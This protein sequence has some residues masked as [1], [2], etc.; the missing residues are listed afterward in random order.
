MKSGTIAEAT[1]TAARP[2]IAAQPRAGSDGRLVG[3]EAEVVAVER[4]ENEGG[5][6]SDRLN[7]R[8][9]RPRCSGPVAGRLGVG[10]SRPGSESRPLCS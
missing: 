5:T 9:V 1:G 2:S 6:V 3:G 8:A 10:P 4:W 7:P